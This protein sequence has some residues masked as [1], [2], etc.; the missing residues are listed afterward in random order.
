MDASNN[1]EL[2]DKDQLESN[3]LDNIEN[4]DDEE[5]GETFIDL[6]HAVEVEENDDDILMDEDDDDGDDDNDKNDTSSPFDRN[7]ESQNQHRNTTEMIED[8]SIQTITN[9]KPSSVFTVGSYMDKGSSTLT[10]VTGGGDDKAYLHKIDTTT[11]ILS[12]I[13]LSHPHTDSVSSVAINEA[14]VS[15]DLTKTP[16][17][18]AVGAYDG[19]MKEY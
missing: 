17:Y 4:V 19:T 1:D 10:V 18:V 6:D 7:E 12:S 16:K 15:S 11:N 3:H 8:M 14:L 5:E 9:H 13:P 2:M